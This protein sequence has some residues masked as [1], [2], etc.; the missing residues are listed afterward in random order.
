MTTGNGGFPVS[1]SNRV[2]VRLHTS[3]AGENRP[4]CRTSGA[5]YSCVKASTVTDERASSTTP[6]IPKSATHG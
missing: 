3:A 1:I 5:A 6:E 2:A 4:L